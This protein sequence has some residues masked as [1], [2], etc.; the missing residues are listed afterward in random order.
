MNRHERSAAPPRLVNPFPKTLDLTGKLFPWDGV[1]PVLLSMPGSPSLYLPCFSSAAHLRDCMATAGIGYAGIKEIQDGPE[2]LSSFEL[3][4]RRTMK[5]IVDPY[6]LP[7]GRV[8]FSEV[9]W[10]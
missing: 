1:Q 7:N 2:F 9:R 4:H 10:P 5:I 6:F 8:R 3:E